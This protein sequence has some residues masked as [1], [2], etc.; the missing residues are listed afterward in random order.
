MEV[1]YTF[2]F[3][4]NEFGTENYFGFCGRSLCFYFSNGWNWRILRI[5]TNASRSVAASKQ[6]FDLLF[7]LGFGHSIIVAKNPC[8]EHSTFVGVAFYKTHDC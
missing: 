5:K 2:G 6:I 7:F 8:D 4:R 3:V 1:F